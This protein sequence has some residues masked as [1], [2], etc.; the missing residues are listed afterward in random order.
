MT[1]VHTA[2]DI[3]PAY[4][5][6]S[7]AEI[8]AADKERE[9]K[10][11]AAAQK[12]S[13]ERVEEK[14][15]PILVWTQRAPDERPMWQREEIRFDAHE[16]F[17][18]AWRHNRLNAFLMAHAKRMGWTREDMVG[19]SRVR[20]LAQ[21]RQQLMFDVWQTFR[22]TLPQIGKLFGGRDNSTVTHALR[23]HGV[24]SVERPTVADSGDKIRSL[25][26]SGMS[27]PDI[28]DHLGW[29]RQAI[30][31]YAHDKPWYIPRGQRKLVQAIGDEVLALY[32]K[33]M[34]FD[35][36][37]KRTGFTRDTI[38]RFCKRS[39]ALSIAGEPRP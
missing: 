29:S 12:R 35:E 9:R 2:L 13:V 27:I 26:E 34:P 3:R 16:E 11:R 14:P 18:P 37:G 28:A 24:V 17:F 36:I 22:P 20:P 10:W 4:E 39:G 31:L 1:A 8:V 7:Y 23:K 30:Q 38:W 5:P 25:W 32:A 21:D 19:P 33:G 6:K 15:K